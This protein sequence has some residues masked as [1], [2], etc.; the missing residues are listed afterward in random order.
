MDQYQGCLKSE[1]SAMVYVL[2]EEQEHTFLL[3]YLA[4]IHHIPTLNASPV[5]LLGKC[6]Y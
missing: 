2:L 6:C 4:I 5:S 1:N 3:A